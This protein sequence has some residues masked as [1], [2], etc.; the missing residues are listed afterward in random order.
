MERNFADR[1][2]LQTAL[3][4]SIVPRAAL[5]AL[6]EAPTWGWAFL[7]SA[8]LAMGA[9]FA[10]SPALDRAIER[11]LPA[12]LAASPQM[13]QLPADQRDTLIAR[14][15]QFTQTAA[16]FACVF[17]P[18]GLAIGCALE[19]A[20]MLV[21]NAIGNGDGTFKKFWALAVN[22]AVVGTG[23]A[24]LAWLAIILLRGADGFASAAEVSNALP[25][26]GTF[27]PPE[28]KAAAAFFGAL[29]VF[30]IWD[31]M[32]LAGGMTIVARLPNR[33]AIAAAAVILLGTGLAPLLG[34]LLEK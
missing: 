5:H 3:D 33:T 6:R 13:A 14:Q 24:S 18:F 25:G 34:V 9:T 17:V 31:A 16:K 32:L 29:N 27:V 4:I 19:A 1:S 8:L 30:T 2:G 26:L 10:M 22:A 7:I 23:I 21:A 11:E 20:I 15:T 12:K 28:A